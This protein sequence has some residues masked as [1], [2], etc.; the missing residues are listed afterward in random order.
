[1]RGGGGRRVGGFMIGSGRS[2]SGKGR[3]TTFEEGNEVGVGM[4]V[5]LFCAV[6]D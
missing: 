6:G 5:S 3:I 1:L 4:C 2:L